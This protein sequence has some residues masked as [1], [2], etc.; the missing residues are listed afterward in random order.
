MYG[1]ELLEASAGADCN[2]CQRAFGKV[3][4][5]VR[6]MPKALVE[7]VEERS[8]AGENNPAIHDVG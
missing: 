3:H 7:T 4:W 8:T 6:L 1:L 2:A 5:H